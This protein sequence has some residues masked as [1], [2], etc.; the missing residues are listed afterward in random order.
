[1]SDSNAVQGSLVERIEEAIRTRVRDFAAVETSE[2]AF[3]DVIA[4]LTRSTRLSLELLHELAAEVAD[5]RAEVAQQ[6]DKS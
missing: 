4:A 6:R 2:T 3:E 1:M 5:L